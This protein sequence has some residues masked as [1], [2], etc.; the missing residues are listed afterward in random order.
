MLV[1]LATWADLVIKVQH[2]GAGA[3]PDIVVNEVVN[4]LQNGYGCAT[5]ANV[6]DLKE[7]D[8]NPQVPHFPTSWLGRL[9]LRRIL[10][11]LET[12]ERARLEALQSLSQPN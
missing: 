9:L 5:P 12:Q 2:P 6:L 3:F 7:G 11:Y 4:R 8:E 1:D 10:S